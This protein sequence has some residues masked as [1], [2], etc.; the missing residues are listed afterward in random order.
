[1]ALIPMAQVTIIL[2]AAVN[3]IASLGKQ[4]VT[5]YLPVESEVKYASRPFKISKFRNIL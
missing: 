3:T 1:M 4:H 2:I 5:I